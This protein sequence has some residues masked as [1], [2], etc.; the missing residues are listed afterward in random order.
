[1]PFVRF[2]TRS[3]EVAERET[4]LECLERHGVDV[5][6]SCRSGVCQSCILQCVEGAVPSNSQK[7]LKAVL[8]QQGY[9]LSCSCQPV[10]DI[11]VARAGS[12]TQSVT[13]TVAEIA[14]LSETILRVR[15]APRGT[16]EYFP[17]QFANFVRP[18]GIVRSYSIASVPA[19]EDTLEFHV[20]V[21]PNGSMSGWLANEAAICD[22]ITITGPMG[23]CFYLKENVEQPMLLVGTGTGLAPLYGIVRDALLQDHSGPIHL[24]HGSLYRKGL[25]LVDELRALAGKH[26]NFSYTPCVLND[27]GAADDVT[28]GAIDALVLGM[29]PSYK[30]WRVYLCGHPDTVRLLQRKIFLGGAALNNIFADAFLPSAAKK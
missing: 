11:T 3:F 20:A 17:G 5:P 24:F 7:G 16:F 12:V 6:S 9:F 1:M 25:Y 19:L 14:R 21:M 27:D 22:T 13:A 2:E 10:E 8:Q 28:V 15:L 30:G 29:Q 18:G 26:A 4:V 23:Q